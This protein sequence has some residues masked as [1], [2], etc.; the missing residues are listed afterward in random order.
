VAGC[1]VLALVAGIFLANSSGSRP[2]GA[3]LTGSLPASMQDQLQ[4]AGSLLG[5][6]KAVDAVKLYDKILKKNPNQVVALAYRGWLVRLA[7][8]KVEGLRYEDRAVAAD[9]TYP[10]AHF[11]RGMMLWQDKSDPAAAVAEFRLF[12]SNR[13]PQAMVPLVQDALRRASAEAGLPSE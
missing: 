9:A 5:E 12:L 3:P 8:L 6:G 1:L 10:D 2:A 7:G 11:F 4:K 13:P